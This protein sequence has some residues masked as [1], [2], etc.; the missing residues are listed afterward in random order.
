MDSTAFDIILGLTRMKSSRVNGGLSVIWRW[1]QLLRCT[2]TLRFSPCQ[3]FLSDI[4]P[5]CPAFQTSSNLHLDLLDPTHPRTNFIA[6][7]ARRTQTPQI[8]FSPYLFPIIQWTRELFQGLHLTQELRALPGLRRS[9]PKT[10]GD[11]SGT[12]ATFSLPSPFLE[13]G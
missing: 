4:S 1:W 13:K 11:S 12:L 2:R 5:P 8:H 3:S 7:W 6:R 10:E 9:F